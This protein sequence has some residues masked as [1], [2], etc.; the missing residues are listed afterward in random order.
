VS[1]GKRKREEGSS[2]SN[3]SWW[4]EGRGHFPFI[5]GGKREWEEGRGHFPFPPGGKREQG[6]S[7]S[8]PSWWEEKKGTAPSLLEGRGR[9]IF[10]LSSLLVGRGKRALPLP[11]WTFLLEGRRKREGRGKR[12][13]PLSS[14]REEGRGILLFSSLLVGRG[15]RALPLGG[16]R[17]EG[18]RV[19]RDSQNKWKEGGQGIGNPPKWSN[20]NGFLTHF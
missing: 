1:R 2:F 14:W 11:S 18:F 12:A 3:P 6:S 8:L 4:E 5:L 20:K 17:E 19:T 10:L 16:K 9:G 15:K 7:F 13:L